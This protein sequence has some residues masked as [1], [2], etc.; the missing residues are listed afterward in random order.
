ME[1]GLVDLTVTDAPITPAV[2]M[3]DLLDEMHRMLTSSNERSTRTEV[4][5]LAQ[6]LATVQSAVTNGLRATLSQY[7]PLPNRV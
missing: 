2:V 3:Q 4:L 1:I 5:P 7:Q 6:A